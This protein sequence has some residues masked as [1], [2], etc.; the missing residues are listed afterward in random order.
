M[1]VTN[2]N[3]DIEAGNYITSSN[4]PGYGQLQDDDFTHSYTVAKATETVKREDM[5]EF[6]RFPD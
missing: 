6:I 5:S 4:I 1:W 3:G 2:V